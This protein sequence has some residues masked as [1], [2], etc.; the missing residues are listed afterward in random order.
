MSA[1]TQADQLAVNTIRILSAAQPEWAKSGHP[2]GAMGAADF[3]H[4]LFSEFIV[5]DPDD[6]TWPFRDRFFL[7]P[8]HMSPMLYSVLALTGRIPLEE[9]ERFRQRG[10]LTPG[11]PERDILHGIENTSGP[12]GQGHGFA[13]GAA[14]AAKFLE[15]RFGDWMDHTIYAFISD[16]GVQEEISQGIGRIAG[17]LG[18]GNLIMFYDSNHIQLSTPTSEAT[19]EDT[20]RKYE[21]WNWHVI[22]IDGNDRDQIRQAL[23]EAKAETGRPTIIIGET[24]MGKGLLD[25]D[26]NPFEG[27]PST[28]GMPVSE[29]GASFEKSVQNLG[30]DPENPFVIPD[31]VKELYAKAAERKRA[32]VAE[33]RKAEAA[34]RAA[35]PEKAEVLDRYLSGE[36]PKLDWEAIAASQQAN[37]ATRA[38]SGH[39]LSYF[40][41]QVGNMIVMSADLANSDKTDAFL[42]KTKPLVADDFSG[43]FLHCGVSELSMAAIAVGMALHGGVIPVC[44][45]FFAFS[46]YQ[47]P[48][49][50]LAALMRVPVKFLWTH[51]AFRVGEDG[52][53]HQPIEQ[54][55]Q[56]RLL[57]KVRNHEG[58]PSML[59]L[60][61]ADAA[62]VTVAWQMALENTETPTGI[63]CTR[64]NIIDVSDFKAAQGA[65]KG[66]YIVHEPDGKPE[67]VVVAN[68]SE[69]GTA[70]EAIKLLPDRKIRL[71]SVPSEGLF[72]EQPE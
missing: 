15:A 61:P 40:A 47:K 23:R 8:G 10:S 20:A 34:W 27:Q 62:E 53:T 1:D 45:T 57:E 38:S 29:A 56:V 51:D 16:G 37:T 52:P 42:K 6:P 18:L 64:Q 30:G 65:K 55:A 2:G 46:D 19:N 32:L 58:K 9:L 22:T 21:S 39:V 66:A 33:R 11:H 67:L 63:I 26:G 72:R 24:V 50:R 43:A 13:A 35:N 48:V 7:D 69:V 36:P 25:P 5:E 28:H 12:L 31:E 70:Y 54:E 60:R 14:I 59:V 3:I 68:G 4:V 41:E 44:G 71:V 49:L 17:R